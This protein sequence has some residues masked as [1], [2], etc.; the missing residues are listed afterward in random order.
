MW[1]QITSKNIEQLKSGTIVCQKHPSGEMVRVNNFT[2]TLETIFKVQRIEPAIH[3]IWDIIL[4]TEH[5]AQVND[6]S[7]T[8]VVNRR[9]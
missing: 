3:G 8:K 1:T 6:I 4:K 5:L 2:A 9:K 7:A